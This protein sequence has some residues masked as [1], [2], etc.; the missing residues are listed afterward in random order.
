MAHPRQSK[1]KPLALSTQQITTTQKLITAMT[2][3][4]M[5]KLN[6]IKKRY[7]I[8]AGLAILLIIAAVLMISNRQSQHSNT[9]ASATKST[10]KASLAV[11][12]VRPQQQ[13]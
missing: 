11:E 7:F 9:P 10:A 1:T 4:K 12:T 8:I 6:S 3:Y 2:G 5:I 13:V